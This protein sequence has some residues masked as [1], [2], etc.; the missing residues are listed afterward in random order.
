MQVYQFGQPF[1]VFRLLLYGPLHPRGQDACLL[2][3]AAAYAPVIFNTASQQQQRHGHIDRESPDMV[4]RFCI[5]RQLLNLFGQILQHIAIQLLTLQGYLF[6]IFNE[7]FGRRSIAFRA[8]FPA[9]FSNTQ[10][11]AHHAQHLIYFTWGQCRK[12]G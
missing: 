8:L 3:E 4:G 9:F 12:F 7:F 6:G 11:I 5:L 10:L 2:L 1:R